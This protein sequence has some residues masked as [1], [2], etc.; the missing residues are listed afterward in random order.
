MALNTLASR[1]IGISRPPPSTTGDLL[2]PSVSK[3]DDEI[4]GQR[5]LTPQKVQF[6]TE[7]EIRVMTPKIE[8]TFDVN[9]RNDGIYDPHSSSSAA[10]S[11]S[12]LTSISSES[13]EP[14]SPIA[15]ILAERLA[16]W[17][18]ISKRNSTPSTSS[19][20]DATLPP[21]DPKQLETIMQEQ[22]SPTAIDDILASTAPAPQSTEEQHS[23]LED[24]IVKEV[25]REFSKGGMYFSYTFG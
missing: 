16:F 6:S 13:S 12:D 24:K 23:E 11:S 2:T 10:S 3:A 14:I 15:K 20:I 1:N 18:R 22:V 17:P 19:G 8:Q 4:L 25:I 21:V 9:K 5:A 7:D